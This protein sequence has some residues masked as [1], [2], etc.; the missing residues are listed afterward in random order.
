MNIIASGLN[1]SVPAMEVSF[2]DTLSHLNTLMKLAAPKASRG[3][4]LNINAQNLQY[5]TGIHIDAS[6][7]FAGSA[8]EIIGGSQ[9]TQG[10]LFKI[11]AKS[12]GG[13]SPIELHAGHVQGGAIMNIRSNKISSGSSLKL[14]VTG[15]Q[16]NA[17]S[18][19]GKLLH[20]ELNGTRI[21]QGIHVSA[22]N[23][24]YGTLVDISAQDSL[25][26]GKLLSVSTTSAYAINPILF[27]ANSM[28]YGDVLRI[29]AESLVAV[30]P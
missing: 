15:R 22:P 21:G 11:N 3:T 25:D 9:M 2:N 28:K 12:T 7:L 4:I 27:E 6:N 8:F 10:S 24:V 26:S 1:S 16:A 19:N 23:M 20:L 5:G 17:V 13:V 30:L 14:Q 18:Q 29:S